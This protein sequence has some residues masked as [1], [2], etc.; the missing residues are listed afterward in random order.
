MFFDKE[1]FFFQLDVSTK[2]EV[3]EKMAAALLAKE[4]VT[5]DY[6]EG[7][8]EREVVFPTGLPTLPYGVA[9]PHT[10]GERVLEPQI[11]FASLKQP[12]NFRVMGSET[13]TIDVKIVFMLALKKA[14]DQLEILQKLIDLVQAEESVKRLGECHSSAEFK[15]IIHEIGLG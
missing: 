1:V 3:F 7:V 5:V 13:E 10:D 15:Q 12:V 14:D 8:K 4:L 6:L 9:I 11:G 2:E